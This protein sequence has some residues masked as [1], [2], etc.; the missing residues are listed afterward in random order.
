MTVC[1]A[2]DGCGLS[3]LKLLLLVCLPTCC[4]P[5]GSND[6]SEAHQGTLLGSNNVGHK[7]CLWLPLFV[8]V[9]I[10]VE[11]IAGNVVALGGLDLPVWSMFLVAVVS[12]AG[13]AADSRALTGC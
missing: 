8:A 2:L 9:T 5:F 1:S 7:S 11:S 10:V 13:R 12:D 3:T 6:C 4:N